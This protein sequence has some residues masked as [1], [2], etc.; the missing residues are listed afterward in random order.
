MPIQFPQTCFFSLAYPHVQ[1]N[2]CVVQ[3][4][5]HLMGHTS[6][7]SVLLFCQWHRLSPAD[8]RQPPTGAFFKP[9]P[10]YFTLRRAVCTYNMFFHILCHI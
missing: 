6:V 2:A 4:P 7:L 5:V 1:P 8:G 3:P 9:V 10:C